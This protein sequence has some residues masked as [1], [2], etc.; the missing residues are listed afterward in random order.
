MGV[1][2]EVLG[3]SLLFTGRITVVS[4]GC[5]SEYWENHFGCRYPNSSVTPYNA[6][7]SRQCSG[8][9]HLSRTNTQFEAQ[10]QFVSDAVMAFAYAFRDM[11][12]ELCKGRGLCPTIPHRRGMSGDMSSSIIG[13]GSVATTYSLS[14]K[15][16]EVTTFG[17]PLGPTLRAS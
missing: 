1:F 6:A 15:S 4:K 9:E 5:L 16:L 3:E 7:T 13:D 11:H 12:K 14:S 8:E 10:L 2:A 17:P